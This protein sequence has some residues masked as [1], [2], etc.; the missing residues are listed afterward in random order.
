MEGPLVYHAMSL[1]K[2]FHDLM[3]FLQ[4]ASVI[5]KDIE[6]GKEYPPGLRDLSHASLDRMNELLPHVRYYYQLSS[7]EEERRGKAHRS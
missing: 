7:H 3:G 4:A 5:L 6:S 1:Q 2:V